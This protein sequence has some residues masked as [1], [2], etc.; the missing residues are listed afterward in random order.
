MSAMIGLCLLPLLAS[1]QTP[2][3]QARDMYVPAL[4]DLGQMQQCAL[5][6][7]GTETIG[8]V[9][10]NI[11]TQVSVHRRTEPN[12]TI[13]YFLEIRNW[14]GTTETQRIV[15]D[16]QRMWVYDILKNEY[17]VYGYDLETNDI[18]RQPEK[19]AMNLLR[20]AKNK[21][22]LGA[23]MA[24][25]TLIESEEAAIDPSR[26]Y[27]QW[28]PWMPTSVISN[29]TA[30]FR[31][32]LSSPRFVDMYYDISNPAPGDYYLLKVRAYQEEKERNS[33][34]QIDW[35]IVV[36]RNTYPASTRFTFVPPTT[37]KAISIGLPQG[38]GL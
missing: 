18:N 22:V 29:A 16:G 27:S 15:G 14:R 13:R 25:Q 34:K 31:A 6:L 1:A 24:M 32:Q 36:E 21:S 26:L 10:T 7:N 28:N 17:S 19:A 3:Q 9:S 20:A 35:Q 12:N 38:G 11:F 4:R 2:A 33:I 30:G 5:L 23:N 37:A 8:G